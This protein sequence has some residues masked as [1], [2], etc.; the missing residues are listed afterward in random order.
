MCG[1]VFIRGDVLIK[2][3]YDTITAI[4]TPAGSG[5]IAI[6]RISG[7]DAINIADKVFPGSQSLEEVPSHTVIYGKIKEKSDKNNN[8]NILIDS[9]LLTVFKSPRS[10]T[11]E[12][13]V[14][15]SCHGGM[16]VSHR[17]LQMILSQGARNAE[18]GEFTQ[19]AFFNGKI[20]LS[21]AEAVADVIS[22]KTEES[23]KAAQVQLEG[24]LSKRISLIRQQILDICSLLELELDFAEEDVEFADRSEVKQRILEAIEVI[25][26]FLSTYERNKIL[27]QGVRTVIVGK[28]N[29]GKSSLLNALVKEERAIVTD[30]PGTTR[31][32]LE[33]QIDIKGIFFRVVDTAGV[34]TAEDAI[35]KKG[36][37][38]TLA[39]LANA[40]IILFLVDGSSGIDHEDRRLVADITKYRNNAKICAAINKIDLQQVVTEKQVATILFPESIIKISV[41]NHTG[42]SS[43]EDALIELAVGKD[44]SFLDHVMVSSIRQKQ[45]L[46][47]AVCYM[48]QALGTLN[49]GLSSEYIAADLKE[50]IKNLGEIM[51]E[52][53]T[54][55]ILDNIF[56][57]F[58]IGK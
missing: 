36:V 6:I 35:E 18:P 15:I 27:K 20:D 21:Q 33:E 58:C 7:P 43:L 51:G 25:E 4:A 12:D 14:E 23:L 11:G 30:F 50:A 13:T 38:R 1:A 28:P 16:Y 56:S 40:D 26:A 55:D 8:N 17:I 42:F 10:Y 37:E 49:R 44:F 53:V 46:E 31:D 48:N 22:A 41:K 47:R 2:D 9:V 54:E 39:Q 3:H 29:V 34:R 19:R 32:T 24:G 5:A 52:V 45:A 57:K